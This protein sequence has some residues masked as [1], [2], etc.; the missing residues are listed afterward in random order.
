[1]FKSKF[2]SNL[3][4]PLGDN[5]WL[6]NSTNRIFR[7]RF[8]RQCDYLL[9][10]N[11]PKKIKSI[12][13]KSWPRNDANANANEDDDPYEAPIFAYSKVM[14][15]LVEVNIISNEVEEEDYK[16]CPNGGMTELDDEE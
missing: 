14:D 7:T 8:L 16:T 2:L 13:K 6:A 15:Q 9:R 10:F 3:Q 5:P 12:L 4:Q 1:M 11:A